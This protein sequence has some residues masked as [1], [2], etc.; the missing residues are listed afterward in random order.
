M[1]RGCHTQHTPAQMLSIK[2]PVLQSAV[3]FGVY[4]GKNEMGRLKIPQNEKQ[5]L[6]APQ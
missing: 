2:S 6:A 1:F 5:A 4:Y 3:Q